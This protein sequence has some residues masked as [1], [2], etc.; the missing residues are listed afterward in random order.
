[1][2]G[3]NFYLDHVNTVTGSGGFHKI[4]PISLGSLGT[5][6]C[7][8]QGKWPTVIQVRDG[9]FYVSNVGFLNHRISPAIDS[10][11]GLVWVY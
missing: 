10:G 9:P 11:A 8:L 6:G 5:V 1:M 4:R 7:K 3:P 2:Q